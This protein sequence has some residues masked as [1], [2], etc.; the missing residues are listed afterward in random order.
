MRTISL[1]TQ[2]DRLTLDL[3]TGRLVALCPRGDLGTNLVASAADAPAFVVQCLEGGEYRVLDSRQAVLTATHTAGSATFAFTGVGG[4]DLDVT[5]TV[6]SAPDDRFSYWSAA[7]RNGSGV[8]LTD[9]QFPFVVV[10]HDPAAHLLLP[11]MQGILESGARLAERPR[12]EPRRW[13]FWPENGNSQHYPGRSFAQ[14][15]AWYTPRCGLYT[16]CDDTEGHV[17]LLRALR[18][19]EGLRLGFAHVG[20]WPALGTR[21]LGYRILLG[22]FTGDWYDAAE[23]YRAWTLRQ[24]WAV[25]LHRRQDIPPWLLASPPHIAI[26]LQGYV[27]AGPAP[28]I[29]QFLPYE[30][31]IPLLQRVAD[32][33]RAPLV[34]VLMSWERGGPWV[35]PDC[36]PPV[37]GE[38]SMT[39][40]CSL[41]RARGWHVGS[42][43]NGTRW[44]LQHLFSG[45]DGRQYFRDHG[46][47]Q[48]LCRQPNG[49]WWHESWDQSWRPSVIA[50]MAQRQ[51]R[52]LASDFVRRLIGWGMESIQFFDQNCNASTF[53]CF[54][55]DHGHPRGPGKW[56]ARAM[57][58]LMADFRAAAAQAGEPE[59]IHSTEWPTNEYCLPLFQQSDVRISVPSSGDPA[60]VP[61]Y[62]Y[63]FHE[64][65]LMHGMMSLGPEPVAIEARTAWE[66]VW[67]EIV[68][69]V[70]TGDGTLL[71]RETWNWAEW[72]PRVGSNSEALE[73]MRVAT[74][75][76]RGAGRDFLVYGRMQRPA[77]VAS[78]LR[79]WDWE[80]R[81]HAVPAV[82][83]CCWQAP[84]GRHGLALANWTG[85][86]QQIAI[87]DPRLGRQATLAAYAAEDVCATVP[88]RAGA[89][90][91]T[92]APRSCAV[93]SGAAP[94]GSAGSVP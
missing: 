75:L 84:D 18:R 90:T 59:V 88:V 76:R 53:P 23:L 3:D 6:E 28:P 82:A 57:A 85:Q 45:Y 31:C 64:C 1:A 42:F 91:I 32:H 86:A 74:A 68:G 8:L 27:D 17:K 35:Y 2:R 40:F 51:T 11:E 79:E 67:G 78:P 33:V 25:P 94:D 52:Q 72:E 41:A 92:L 12:D 38:A 5:L 70:M 44:V 62:H 13:Q 73:M 26:R 47:E 87:R 39:R 19:P 43:C 63:L 69:A 34:A 37:G 10:P 36:F 49:A 60:F 24:H 77:Q 29:E 58:E 65:M 48:G 55:T 71:N 80:G 93:L 50:C 14:F 7:V 46:G 16:A 81:H 9:L 20:D 66:C 15:L 30:K 89:A 22:S 54:A 61:V 4:L 21:K 56:M 83:H